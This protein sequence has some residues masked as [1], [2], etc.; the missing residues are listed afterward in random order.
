MRRRSWLGLLVGLLLLAAPQGD[1]AA[2]RRKRIEWT[3]VDVRS[4]A[5]CAE[6]PVEPARH[7]TRPKPA[8]SRASGGDARP[9]AAAA[10]GCSPERAVRAARL[11][12][13]LL[14]E[15]SRR[16][17]WGKGPALQLTA[18][19]TEL[20]WEQHDDVLRLE[21]AVVGRIAGG[22]GARSRIRVGGRPAEQARARGT[23]DRGHR[24]GHAAGGHGTSA[25]S[26]VAPATAR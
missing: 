16:A 3:A 9:P 20:A 4:R 12:K 15:A 25:G 19:I 8:R 10:Q 13:T 7:E 1:A 21:V 17:D 11:L 5:L 6:S 14:Q 22:A 2:A 23:A 24:P 26:A 18:S